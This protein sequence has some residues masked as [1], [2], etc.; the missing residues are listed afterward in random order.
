MRKEPPD[1][2]ARG[3]PGPLVLMSGPGRYPRRFQ[4]ERGRLRSVPAR[5]GKDPL[6]SCVSAGRD[7]G[8]PESYMRALLD[9]VSTALR[10]SVCAATPAPRQG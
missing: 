7:V 6:G 10:P 3:P 9:H 5:E 1:L 4:R 8:A 2:A